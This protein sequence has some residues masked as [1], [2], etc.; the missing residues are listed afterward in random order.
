MGYDVEV[1]LMRQAASYLA[2]PIF[3]VDPKGDLVYFNEPAEQLLGLR[4]EEVGEMPAEE[5]STIFVPTDERGDPLPPE[6]LPLMIALRELR[7]AHERFYIRGLDGQ[8][9]EL[10]VTAFPLIGQHARGLGAVAIFWEAR[11]AWR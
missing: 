10:F 1:I 4:Y 7:P 11:P 2:M 9:R 5:W 8:E 6:S 3:V